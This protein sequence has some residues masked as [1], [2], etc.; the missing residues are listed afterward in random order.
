MYRKASGSLVFLALL[1][2]A[3]PGS[4]WE[5]DLTEGW[6]FNFTNTFGYTY[7]FNND[8]K[9]YDLSLQTD[10][11]ER[12]IELDDDKFHQFMNKL[13]AS[14]RNG[15]FR[16]GTRLDL[17]LFAN[18]PFDQQCGKAGEPLWCGNKEIRYQNQFALERIYFTATRPEFSVTLGDFYASF[19]KGIALSLI[20]VDELGQDTSIRG[21]KFVVHHKDLGLTILAGETNPLNMDRT[22]GY[23][24]PWKPEP[25]V[26]GR[27]EYR[28][29][30][31]VLLGAHSVL[32]LRD[33]HT[34]NTKTLYD[35]VWGSGFEVPD[36]FDG[37]LSL[38]GE[39][40]LL[41]TVADQ[42]V[43]RGPGAEGGGLDGVAGYASATLQVG[44]LSILGE[45]KYYDNFELVAFEKQPYPMVYNWAPTCERK[46]AEIKEGNT[47]VSGGRMRLDYNLGEIG[48][49][50][51]VLYGNYGYFQNWQDNQDMQ[52][53]APFGGVE[54]SW[55]GGEFQ[56]N[57]GIR[58]VHDNKQD[59]KFHHDIHLEAIVDQR[60][61]SRHS[62][63]LRFLLLDRALN[64]GVLEEWREMEASISYK[65]SPHITVSVD[66]ERQEDPTVVP[67]VGPNFEPQ[68]LNLFSGSIRYYFL[69][70][71]YVNLKIGENRAGIKCVN[72][73]CRPMP[74]FSGVELFVVY[75]Y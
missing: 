22:T 7:Y 62:L 65:W 9:E 31:T 35:A 36:L 48:P 56:L 15:N 4:G 1:L 20:Q 29:A 34:G 24:V 3:R 16:L 70:S 39:F 57:S 60:L 5:F 64:E 10:R 54:V 68:P 42:K 28:I 75:R 40:N 8:H 18:T 37:A 2:I 58:Y 67:L 66:Y 74:A 25:I 6:D 51:L 17:N 59:Q 50:E 52:I 53:H 63:G 72:G 43:T 23:D 19:G 47:S 26:G 44:D 49:V 27:I 12:L 61:F 38:N 32:F 11:D 41:Q 46:K 30:D 55:G 45:F 13:D 71:S 69:S 14:V 33:D 73:V 21:G